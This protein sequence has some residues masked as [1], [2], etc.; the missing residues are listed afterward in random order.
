MILELIWMLRTHFGLIWED[1]ALDL[2]VFEI[3]GR[4]EELITTD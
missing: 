3:G 4:Q 1:I 2:D